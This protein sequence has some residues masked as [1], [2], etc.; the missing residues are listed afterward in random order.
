M[1]GEP[2]R[3][4]VRGQILG[5]KRSKANQHNHTALI[6]VCVYCCGIIL[7]AQV[8]NSVQL[9]N[10]VAV[11]LGS[12]DVA[13]AAAGSCRTAFKHFSSSCRA[14]QCSAKAVRHALQAVIQC[15]G[16]LCLSAACFGLAAA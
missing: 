10:M 15:A 16:G 11:G 1:G 6:K 7:G 9:Q 4:H 2:V 5:Y 12:L 13:H 14:A 3:L 8:S